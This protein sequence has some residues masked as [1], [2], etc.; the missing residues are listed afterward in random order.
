M[1]A[2]LTLH[3]K[4]RDGE[5]TQRRDESGAGAGLVVEQRDGQSAAL[6]IGS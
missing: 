6:S 2:I 5:L 4:V 3:Q 1:H